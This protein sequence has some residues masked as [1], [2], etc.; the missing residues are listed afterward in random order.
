MALTDEQRQ[1]AVDNLIAGPAS[2]TVD[3]NSARSHDPKTIA[4]LVDRKASTAAVKKSPK[5]GLRFSRFTPGGA[6]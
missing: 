3:G 1:E 2:V 6:T 4:D 5:R